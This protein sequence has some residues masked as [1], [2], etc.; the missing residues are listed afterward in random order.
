MGKT[1]YYS[2]KTITVTNAPTSDSV[3]FSG[4]CTLSLT[5]S[6]EYRFSVNKNS[7]DKTQLLEKNYPS[8]IEIT[9]SCKCGLSSTGTRTFEC[10][11]IS[12]SNIIQLTYDSSA[13]S[14][15]A[16]ARRPT[17]A[18]QIQAKYTIRGIWRATTHPFH[19]TKSGTLW[20]KKIY[21]QAF[22][23]S[24]VQINTNNNVFLKFKV[25]DDIYEL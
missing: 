3:K 8:S 18:E 25:G 17:G 13:N 23:G 7:V 24:N 10:N 4:T 21:T 20:T 1:I 6:G 11:N 9:A 2:S 16:S 5:I 19:I 14:I 22:E 15:I 12:N